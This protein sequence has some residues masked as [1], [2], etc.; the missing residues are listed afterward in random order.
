LDR[1]V[2]IKAAAERLGYTENAIRCK[3]K[4]GVWLEGY[5]YVRTPDHRINIDMD[6]YR[7][8]AVGDRVLG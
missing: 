4:A 3:I 8:W 2:T 6:G 5:E 7:R 1:Y